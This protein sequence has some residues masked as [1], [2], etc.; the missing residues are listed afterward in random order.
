[1]AKYRST[2]FDSVEVYSV[3]SFQVFAGQTVEFVIKY[4][5]F[6]RTEVDVRPFILAWMIKLQLADA[7]F[8]F[9]IE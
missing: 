4:F 5:S 9:F 6:S 7:V 2:K 1:M 3:S 8:V